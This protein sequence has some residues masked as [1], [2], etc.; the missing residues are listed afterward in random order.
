[1]NDLQHNAIIFVGGP[2]QS[3]LRKT[4]GHP[5]CLL[6]IPGR[7]SLLHSWVDTLKMS[8]G[9]RTI[10]IVTGRK[11]DAKSLEEQIQNDRLD[12]K[13]EL[14]VHA[15]QVSHRG[16]AGALKD[17]VDGRRNFENLIFIEGN[18]IPPDYPEALFCKDYERVDVSGVLG[19]TS[20]HETAGMI[21][22]KR[23]MLDLVPNMGFF[24][25]KEQLIPRV[26]DSGSRILVKEITRQSIRLSTPQAYLR[27][28]IEFS[29][30][31]QGEISGPYI[32]SSAQVDSS[33]ILGKNVIVGPNVRIDSNCLIQDSVIMEGA[34]VG[35][36]STLIRSIITRNSTVEE[37]TSSVRMPHD[38]NSLKSETSRKKV[39]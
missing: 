32:S 9:V 12:S 28:L 26:L 22:M 21:L 39:S 14:T 20:E 37:G 34:R 19:R 27:Q 16:T 1:M 23:E 6:P 33:A 13:V 5:V 29:P 36:N 24:D 10:S 30:L 17:F 7:R 4:A 11:E 25:F 15:D 35:A 3:K 2:G 8:A 31:E 18:R 38:L